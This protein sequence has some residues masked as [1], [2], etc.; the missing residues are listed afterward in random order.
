MQGAKEQRLRRMINTPQ[1]IP[2][3][4]IRMKKGWW[5]FHYEYIIMAADR[6]N[7]KF[8]S[9]LFMP[10][11]WQYII[12]LI[13][14]AITICYIF[15]P[16]IENFFVFYPQS[17]F[18]FTPEE[19]RLDYKDVYFNSEDGEKLHGW[20]F[21][22]K[23]EYPVIL[24][25]HGN[26]GNISHRLDNIR[27]L[28]ERNLQVFIFDY[29][30][31]GKSSGSPSEKGIYMDGRAAYDYLADK[32]H[33][34]PEKIVLFGRSLGGSVAIDLALNRDAGSIIVESAFVSTKDMAKTMFLFNMLSF[35]LPRNYNNLEK[36]SKISIPK[37]IIHSEDDEIVPFSMGKKLFEASREPKYFFSI[38]GAGH[39][40]TYM[41]GGEKYLR[42][43]ASFAYDSKIP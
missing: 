15:Y 1:R 10:I 2:C 13:I 28:T 12:L 23:G 41:D 14:F 32:E 16:K 42:T 31:Y 24:F 33:I 25:C 17:S 38:K 35:V 27:L 5:Q 20:F 37:L 26:A 39:N 6:I 9:I 4:W 30:G 43:F 34:P 40:D 7:N 21:P 36:I 3:W 29:R 11:K 8:R 22:L 19:L 18:D